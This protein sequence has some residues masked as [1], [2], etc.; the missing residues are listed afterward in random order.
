MRGPPLSTRARENALGSRTPLCESA[1][2]LRVGQQAPGFD[3]K[4]SDGKPIRLEDFRGKKNVVLYFYPKDFTRVCTK[5][6]CGFR[7]MYEELM[8]KDTEV[9]GVSLDTDDS[10]QKFA[11]EYKVPFPLVADT[12]RT[13]AKSY[14]A[15]GPLRGL[16]GIVKRVTFVIDKQGNIAD[17]LQGELNADTHLDGVKA[18]LAKLG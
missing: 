9:I 3:V 1:R 4:A 17:I 16:I 8:G 5:E 2:V 6:T 11:T 15:I 14:E 7:D 18:A 10:H 13:L 12:T